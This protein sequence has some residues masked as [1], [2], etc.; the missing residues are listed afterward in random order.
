VRLNVVKLAVIGAALFA[1]VSLAPA[2]ASTNQAV[3]AVNANVTNNCDVLTQP[4]TLNMSYNP[5]TNTSTPGTSSFTYECTNGASV[6]VTPTSPNNGGPGNGTGGSGWALEPGGIAYYLYNDLTCTTNE[7]TNGTFGQGS[8]NLS[9]GTGS[10]QTYNICAEIAIG[11]E[12]AA[13]GTYT[14]TV[15]FTFN[16][17]P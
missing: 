17:G 5:T 4:A 16:F 7:L 12:N 6:S 13:L 10:S 9:A 1:I 15:T 11:Q 3:L 2:A 8:Q 14:D